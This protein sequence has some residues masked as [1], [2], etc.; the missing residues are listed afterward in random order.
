MGDT[1]QSE[2]ILSALESLLEHKIFATSPKAQD[3][4]RYVVTET[5]EGRGD[6]LSGTTIAQD[7]FAK[8]AD[9]D[10]L[11]NSVVRVTAR[12][13]RYMLQ[14]Y[15]A[16]Q[17]PPPAVVI[18]IPKGG[19][20]PHF[21]YPSTPAPR[22]RATI[23][24]PV[25]TVSSPPQDRKNWFP[26]AAALL[27]AASCAIIF[28]VFAAK[29]DI[30]LSS[31]ATAEA[32]TP[33]AQY[34]HLAASYPSIAVI[35]F[36]NQTDDASYDFLEQA[37]Q[38]QMTEDL[39]RFTLTRPIAYEKSY[40]SLLRNNAPK[41]DY[42]ITGV[43]LEVEP[44][45]DIYIK[46]MDI[47]RAEAIFENRIRRAPG[48]S[49][50]YDSLYNIVSELS[51]NF[52]GLEGVI[53]KERLGT[54]QTKISEDTERLA[55]LDAFECYSLIGTLMQSPS[56]DLYKSI[57]T[58]LETSLEA[59][60]ENSSLLAGFGWITYIGAVS[61]E[62]VVQARSVNP[63]INKESGIEM[64][65]DAIRL[66][67]ENAWAQQ[68]L[69]ALKVRTGDIQGALMHAE[70]AVMEN[71]ANPD[72]LTWLSLCLAHAG[73]WDRAMQVA[74]EA[75]DRNPEPTSQYFYTFFMKALHDNDSAAMTAAAKTLTEKEN[76]YAKVYSYLAAIAANDEGLKSELWPDVQDMAK[77]N[78]NDIMNVIKVLMPSQELQERARELLSEGGAISHPVG[79]TLPF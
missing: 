78:N 5:L 59:N 18:S 43:I 66:D 76:Y 60:P 67:P 46:V 33:L 47:Q 26:W 77:R 51:G 25:E 35:K 42:A 32:E 31:A 44:E 12:R 38:K 61:H 15:Y 49:L 36:T 9:F 39:S 30:P 34:S 79:K 19:Y 16:K 74:Q 10:P 52:A 65:E 71:P 6:A 29:S 57:Y 55:D 1:L 14:D 27:T 58:C 53:V 4:L 37:L 56:P 11:Q 48:Q 63:D 72:N 45:I 13:L 73:K 21:D 3:F 22:T 28:W 20:Q 41:Y 62:P 75:L 23:S 24:A 64:M 7:V 17:N 54:I 69:S 70:T 2:E 40:E 68:A 50:Y 8:D